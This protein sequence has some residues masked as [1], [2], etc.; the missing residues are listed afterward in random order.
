MSKVRWLSFYVLVTCTLVFFYKDTMSNAAQSDVRCDYSEDGTM[1]VSGNGILYW[2]AIQ[3]SA[4]DEVGYG[5]QKVVIQEGITEI[6]A[7]CF[8]DFDMTELKLP[9]SLRKIGNRAFKYCERLKKVELPPGLSEIP[10]EC[11]A[12]CKSLNEIVITTE[13]AAIRKDAF[14]GCERLKEL[15]VPEN[16][17]IWE[18]PIQ[19]C[20]SLKKIV[21]HSA[22]SLKLDTCQGN[23]T[24]YVQ[25]KKAG[26]LAPGKMAVSKGKKYKISYR[27]LGGKKVGNL[28]S[29][30]QYG[31]S[32]K[33]TF[34]VRKKGFELLGW[35]N[36]ADK[37][38][39]YYQSA[40]SPSLAKNIVLEPFWVKYK[41]E[42]IKKNS[43]KISI[44]DK[45]AVVPFGVFD[46]RYSKSKDMKNAKYVRLMG[47]PKVI[48]KLKKNQRYY[49][50]IAYTEMEADDDD[51]KSIWVGKRSV[52]IRK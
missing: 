35:Y 3:E 26:K 34:H 22:Q 8:S 37:E 33:L 6:S 9:S 11:F 46:V 51:Y 5:I 28:P 38:N 7:G 15:I 42:N 25:G 2:T 43:V 21:N 14:K 36:P 24:W 19:Q 31:S 18:D 50:E 48:H 1:I 27:L 4:E 23:K 52:V 44:D 30:Y 17:K 13:L 16:L 49:F 12:G 29:G 20:P 45:N 47:S 39:P 32:K 40:I 41:V 10:K